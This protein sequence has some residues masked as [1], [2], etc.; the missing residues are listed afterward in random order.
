M[1]YYSRAT[2]PVLYKLADEFVVCDHWFAS[3]LSSTWPNRKYLHSGRRDGDNDTQTI[4]ISGFQTR[5]FYDALEE[6][7]DPETNLRLSWKCYFTDLP[8]LAF[9]YGFSARHLRNFTHVV[10]FVNDCR[11]DA[12]P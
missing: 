2:L 9:W 10:D 1:G 6:Q 4:P 11:E 5:P 3:L 7:R 8:F 12:L